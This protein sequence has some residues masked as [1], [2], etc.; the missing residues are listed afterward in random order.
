MKEAKKKRNPAIALQ[1]SLRFAKEYFKTLCEIKK[2]RT[3][4]E[5]Q[6]SNELLIIRR[7]LWVSLIIEIGRLF[8]TFDGYKEVISLKKTPFF[9]NAPWKD[10]IDSMHG[11]ATVSKMIK[12]RKTFTAHLG[13][14]DEG[15]ISVTEICGSKLGNLLDD[16]DQPLA[17]FGLWFN[18]NHRGMNKNFTR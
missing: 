8:D 7:A 9:K 10:K 6:E 16:L 18:S 13:E 14:D 15:V 11:D 12:T 2:T 1:L 3:D 17:E 5:I 4:I